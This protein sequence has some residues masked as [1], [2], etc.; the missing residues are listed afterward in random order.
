MKANYQSINSY[1][2]ICSAIGQSIVECRLP[3][4]EIGA[5]LLC[6]PRV[7]LE[8]ATCDNGE[9]RYSGKLVLSILY[10]GAGGLCRAERGAEFYHK[11]ENPAIAPAYSAVGKL[12][13]QS[14][15]IRRE[16]GQLIISC[17]VEAKFSVQGERRYTYLLG[18]EGIETN[19]AP[20]AIYGAYTASAI[21]EEEDEFECDYAQD[22]LMHAETATISGVHPAVGEAEIRGELCLQFCL[23]R[24][25]GSVAFYERLTPIKAEVILDAITPTSCLAAEVKVLSAQ[26]SAATDEERGKSKIVV[27]YRLEARV[28]AYEKEEVEVARDAYST[29]VEIGL[30]HEKVRTVYALNAKT[31]TQRVQGTA[32]LGVGAQGEKSLLSVLFPTATATLQPTDDGFELQGAVEAK[33]LYKTE[34]GIEAVDVALPFFIPMEM[35][36]GIAYSDVE[37]NVFGFSLRIR[38]NGETEA[39][40]TVQVRVQPYTVC[41]EGYLSDIVEGEQKTKKTCAVSIYVPV[42]GDDL[43]SIS[44]RLSVT[45]EELLIANPNLVFP[46]KGDERI[47]IYRQKTENLQK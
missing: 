47:V 4:G 36:K 19:T 13:V 20:A 2:E 41:E 44:K 40:G 14:H 22:V 16:G 33:A 28:T 34:T 29:D 15:K 42:A 35:P 37:C 25:D 3:A 6:Q 27:S 7:T 45:G 30:K 31:A 9:I 8:E 21:F 43:W 17:V 1:G 23:L 11:A 5:V 18:G 38:A 10:E 12:N 39:E 24:A 26:V 32:I 46:L